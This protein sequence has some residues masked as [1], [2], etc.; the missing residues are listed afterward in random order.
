[1]TGEHSGG[2]E[3]SDDRPKGLV[4]SVLAVFLSLTHLF[5]VL[6]PWL[7]ETERNIFHFAGFS[8]MCALLYPMWGKGY[9]RSGSS[10]VF[11][12][13]FGIVVAAAAAYLAFAESWIYERGVRLVLLDWVAGI[14]V[15]AGAIE[16]T[17]RAA[18]LL[19]P[20][21]V[22]ISL[23]YV[24]FWGAWIGG[25]FSFPGLS[26]ETV[27]FRSLYGDDALFGNIARI[28]STYVFLF[29]IFGAFLIRSGAGE[30]VVNAA[31]IVAGRLSGGPGFV[32]LIAS[33]LTGTI[34]GSA[35]ANTA[36]TGVVTIPLMKRAGFSPKFSAAIETAASTGGQLMPPIM[37]A[38]AFVMA[39]FTQIPYEHIVLVAILPAILY[40]LSV[41]FFVRIEA[42]RLNLTINDLD[43]EHR[44]SFWEAFRDGGASFI[45]PITVLIALLMVRFTPTYAA[46]ISILTVIVSSWLTKRPMG[47]KRIM[48]ALVDGVVNMVPS[49]VLLCTVGLVVN[50]IAT[51]GIG[52]TF[53]LMIAEWS[54]GN[55]LVAITLIAFASLILG[56]GLPVT[57]A[58]IV[59][60]TLSAPALA[61]MI[62]D[63]IVIQKI[64]AGALPDA[65][66]AI[67][68]LHSPDAAASSAGPLSYD[69]AAEL[70][71]GLPL[72][73][74]RPL[75]NATVP[76][77][78]ATTVLLSAH[79]IIFW[80]SQDSNVTPPVCLAAFTA[81]TI[82]RSPP[83]ATGLTSWKLAKGLY[84]VPILFA[85]TPLLSGDWSAALTVFAFAVV[86]IYGVA[87]ALQGACEYELPVIRRIVMGV[88]GVACLWPGALLV[89]LAGVVVVFVSLAANLMIDR[90]P[91][92]G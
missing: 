52:N 63:L 41:G 51:A 73:I 70:V 26:P 49:A 79:M 28:S 31:R 77:A 33:A 15:I 3:V 12:I 50:V 81:A 27:L 17:R 35:I 92:L 58:Y 72:E 91:V 7:S 65:A 83:M 75:R 29:V 9:A 69:K 42:R 80:L 61:G 20:V 53:S 60:A 44:P 46:V 34:S 55:L 8:L 71:A 2:V 11:D 57:A 66:K 5:L 59:L 62:S 82:A 74:A 10:I 89:N 23:T 14:I 47:L 86:G 48:Q 1:V 24:T 4:V 67:I 25:V 56:M 87:A 45:I 22:V 18:G 38:G 88:G 36:S 19:I 90:R 6:F 30:F 32:A 40:F 76:P 54:S 43:E 16:F 85:Y 84:I 21:L 37:G 39:G 78:V 64:A 13:S 68:M